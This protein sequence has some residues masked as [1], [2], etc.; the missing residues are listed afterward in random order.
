MLESGTPFVLSAGA[1]FDPGDNALTYSGDAPD[2]AFDGSTAELVEGTAPSVTTATDY[3]IKLTAND[4]TELDQSAIFLTLVPGE[5]TDTSVVAH[6]TVRNQF[7]SGA[8]IQLSASESS[9]PPP[10]MFAW[11]EPGLSSCRSMPTRRWSTAI[12]RSSSRWW[13]RGGLVPA[14]P[15]PLRCCTSCAGGNLDT[16]G[17]WGARSYNGG[18]E[19][20]TQLPVCICTVPSGGWVRNRSRAIPPIRRRLPATPSPGST[21]VRPDST[22]VVPGPPVDR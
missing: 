13:P 6:I 10:L 9:G 4:G 14:I 18:D 11:T 15:M 19:V 17:T 8:P 5:S 21:W 22:P 2:L 7:E 20:T 3:W 12:P 1:S 16:E